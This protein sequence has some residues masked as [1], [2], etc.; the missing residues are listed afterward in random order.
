MAN[1]IAFLDVNP[2]I[3]IIQY[4]W[5]DFSG[6]LRAR[7]LTKKHCLSLATANEPLCTGAISM[8]SLV[9]NSILSGFTST[10]V[11][12]IHPDWTSLTRTNF[13][14]DGSS[15]D[16]RHASVICSVYKYSSTE[17]RRSFDRCPHTILKGI[18][19]DLAAKR[20]MSFLVG[21]EIE[22][23]LARASLEDGSLQGVDSNPGHS[24]AAGLRTPRFHLI[25]EY[26]RGIVHAG[27]DVQHFHSEGHISQYEIATGPLSP[28]SAIDKLVLSHEIIRNVLARHGQR[29]TFHPKPI[30][31]GPANGA[32]FHISMQPSLQEDNF[33]A[34]ILKFLPALCAFSLPSYDSYE[35]VRPVE[36]GEWV[37]WGTHNRD[38]PLRKVSSGHW[39][40]RCVDATANMS[41][42]LAAFLSAGLLGLEGSERLAWGDCSSWTSELDSHQREQLNMTI[43]LPRQLK[44][45]LAILEVDAAELARKMGSEVLDAY[46][47]VKLREEQI[48]GNLG[49]Q[50]RKALYLACF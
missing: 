25:E 2:Q 23:V 45:A 17:G 42:V 7:I 21:F 18:L 36:A 50:E 30:I 40:I 6:I 38:L 9:D 22:F 28:I 20:G 8:T 48:A 31:G 26:V 37:G 33:I 41:L 1:L 46:M 19:D 15:V 43:P 5:L 10:G 3:E 35:R 47:S 24:A 11:H 14:R 12:K 13:G 4:Q 29:A 16:G 39:E 44:N 49:A 32:H 27:I 34:G